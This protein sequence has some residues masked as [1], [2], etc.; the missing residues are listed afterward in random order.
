MKAVEARPFEL[1][2]PA[3]DDPAP[4]SHT[5]LEAVVEMH[6]DAVGEEV[7]PPKPLRVIDQ[8][9]EVETDRGIICANHCASADADD[10]IEW[11]AMPN[12][13]T[14]DTDV[15]RSTK[16]PRAED[17]GNPNRGMFCCHGFA[18]LI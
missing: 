5:W 10:A 1:A 13:L 3:R 14:E 9:V 7:A 15:R 2:K 12:Q 17:N 6:V 16:T 11:H 8:F 4:A 18:A